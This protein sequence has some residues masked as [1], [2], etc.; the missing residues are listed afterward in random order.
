M[1][2]AGTGCQ[3]HSGT[4]SMDV[5]SRDTEIDDSRFHETQSREF[6][7][8][9][10]HFRIS[11]QAYR[12][13]DAPRRPRATAATET[14]RIPQHE[15]SCRRSRCRVT[16]S[17]ALDAGHHAR[18]VAAGAREPQSHRP[19]R[20]PRHQPPQRGRRRAHAHRTRALTSTTGASFRRSRRAVGLGATLSQPAS[21][22]L[23]RL[24][25]GA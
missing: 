2:W 11:N 3:R 21:S 20:I 24:T 1:Q 15:M 18:A 9:K 22:W 5:E 10:F 8:M 6:R 14:D 4:A 25:R 23:K 12:P 13:P 17:P 7:F 16:K 19:H